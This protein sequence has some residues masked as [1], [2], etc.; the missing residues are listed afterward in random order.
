MSSLKHLL[1]RLQS[2][3]TL[4]FSLLY[5]FLGLVIICVLLAFIF[6]Q[7]IGA[8]HAQQFQ[9][10]TTQSKRMEA[11]YDSQGRD[12][13]LD[14]IGYELQG[15][16]MDL[17]LFLD[18]EGNKLLGNIDYDPPAFEGSAYLAD[19]SVYRD[20]RQVEAKLRRIEL[21][22]DELLLGKDLRDI[23]ALR[24][25]MLRASLVA[26]V[27]GLFF[28]VLSAY[29]FRGDI[30]ANLGVI[31]R[32]AMQI[33]GGQ[34]QR[35]IP[36]ENTDDELNLLIKELNQ[37]LDHLER[38]LTGVRYVSETI[39]HNLR[40]PIMRIVSHLHPLAY[41][42][43]SPPAVQEQVRRVLGEL[44]DL[45]VLFDKL[46]QISELEAG[47]YRQTKQVVSL[48]A[49]LRDLLELYQPYAEDKSL[50]LEA[51]LCPDCRVLGDTDLLASALSNLLD[52]ACKYAKT[53]L[54]VRL[55]KH[56]H[57]VVVQVEDDGFEV[58]A[59]VL[60][61]LGTHFYRDPAVEHIPG[62]GLGLTSVLSIMRFHEGA[63]EFFN[64][65]L[66]GLGVRLSFS[67]T[68]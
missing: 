32:T 38:S 30:E 9:Q 58:S 48:D 42:A 21:G 43:S 7:V 1:V 24:S 3:L 37:M 31:R 52:N 13:V 62:T 12:A 50:L 53:R 57:A 54:H 59:A 66:G 17:W 46:L 18:Q 23:Y 33:R 49:L 39:T 25:L 19:V 16:S 20:G 27:V 22:S 10:L 40:T 63:C 11:L 2:S 61:R 64:S 29:W 41:E 47:V 14:Y 68:S 65:E 60:A 15:N 35:R 45:T 34:F 44:N 55:F 56:H 36:V 4:R 28:V 5:G 8:L 26:V 51:S 6:L 67:A